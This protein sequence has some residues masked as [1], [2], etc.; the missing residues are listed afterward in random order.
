MTRMRNMMRNMRR[1]GAWPAM[2]AVPLIV[3]LAGCSEDDCVTC[4][5]APPVAPTQVY[6]S[7]GDGQVVVYWN[8]YPEIYS[9]RID[10]YRIWSRVFTPGDQ[11]DPSRE[12]YLIGEV[13]VGQNHDPYSGQYSY[14][15]AE[16]DNAV[17][18]EYAVSSFTATD[19]SY[20]SFEFV[21]DTPLPMSETP[22]TIH[23]LDGE[24]PALSGFDF[25]R[26]A[27]F[28]EYGENG[29]QGVVDPTVPGTEADVRVRF[30]QSD[31][32]WL[33]T[34]RA[35]VRIQDYGTFLDGDGVLDFAG[36]SWAPEFGWSESGVVELIPGHIYVVEIY[37]EF[38][39]QSLHYAKLGVDSIA[40]G[41]TGPT[42]RVMWAY[43]LVNGLPEL[44]APEPVSR[45]DQ[46]DPIRL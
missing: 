37:D 43:Q 38:G 10:G 26:A 16:V 45:G 13:P 9:D 15:D 11:D 3:A 28:G 41:P 21:V 34:M 23:D 44:S 39:A 17:D 27:Q 32:P 19:E 31:V 33:E 7:S 8:D 2:L 18:Y 35:S 40:A 46:L 22:V 1:G 20:L 14:V 36:V 42:V 29:D 25:S 5:D 30:D 4:V 24:S 12:F 6:S